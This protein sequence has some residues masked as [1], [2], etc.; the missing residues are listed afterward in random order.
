M[1]PCRFCP[2][3]FPNQPTVQWHEALAPSCKKAHNQLLSNLW[4]S[5]NTGLTS[6]LQ[7]ATAATEDWAIE[8]GTATSLDYSFTIHDESIQ[9]DESMASEVQPMN[10]H[11]RVEDLP[12]DDWRGQSWQ[13]EFPSHLKCQVQVYSGRG[14]GQVWM[15]VDEGQGQGAGQGVSP[16]GVG[17]RLDSTTKDN[18]H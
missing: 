2:A 18:E 11:A 3:P 16:A 15:K 4:A 10:Q 6:H 1:P 12:H 14:S 7:S 13:E 9:H 8:D 17:D 5:R